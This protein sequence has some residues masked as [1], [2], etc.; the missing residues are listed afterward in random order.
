[1]VIKIEESNSERAILEAAE[2]VFLDKGYVASRTTEIAHQA[3]VTHAMLHYYFR[4]K[5]NLFNK[6]FDEKIILLSN[7]FSL[8]LEQELPFFEKLKQAIETHFDF[9]VENPKLPSF[10]LREVISSTE[11]RDTFIGMLFPKLSKISGLLEK[12]I[13]AEAEKG[14]IV[15]ILPADLLLNIASLN[16]ASV[17]AMLV[18]FE[19]EDEQTLHAKETFLK[20]R[21]SN[22]V[23]FILRS[24]K[25]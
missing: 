10:L 4:T 16:A 5:E 1:M 7:S 2:K 18:L 17:V 24:L 22:N 12:E 14:T 3:G 23:E 11:R 25:K 9:L 13:N 15:N 19:K 6:V 8:V 21:K 20:Q